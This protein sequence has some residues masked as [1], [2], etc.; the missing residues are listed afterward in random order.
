[1]EIT[2]PK[3]KIIKRGGVKKL[4]KFSDMRVNS[5]EKRTKMDFIVY[6]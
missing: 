3:N 1:M 5:N 6:K 4:I 2:P